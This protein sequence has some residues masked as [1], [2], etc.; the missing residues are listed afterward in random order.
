M[1]D[2][3]TARLTLAPPFSYV[4]PGKQQTLDSNLH[5]P[6]HMKHEYR[7]GHLMLHHCFIIA[8]H[9]FLVMRGPAGQLR[10]DRGI[11]LVGERNELQSNDSAIKSYPA[12]KGC[13]WTFSASHASHVG[14]G[15][16]SFPGSLILPPPGASKERAWHTLVNSFP[17]SGR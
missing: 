4:G 14:E 10:S 6:N 12:T 1:A 17:E 7:S 15:S 11:N 9:I 16:T 5:L 2:L 3:P 8:Y 13:D